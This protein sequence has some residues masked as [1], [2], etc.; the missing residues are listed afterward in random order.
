MTRGFG[1]LAVHARAIHADPE[2]ARRIAELLIDPR[3]PWPMHLVRPTQLPGTAVYPWPSGKVPRT[4]LAQ[5]MFD[6]LRADNTLGI[7]LVASRKDELDHVFA[8]IAA[9]HREYRLLY[10]QCSERAADALGPEAVERR[11]LLAAL[12][13]PLTV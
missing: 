2:V 10:L 13:A 7:H 9:G 8:H 1:F 4:G 6:V 5:T 11:Q 3:W 12:L